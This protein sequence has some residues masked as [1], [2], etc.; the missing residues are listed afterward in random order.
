MHYF[1]G[2]MHS[3]AY[4]QPRR[5]H[6]TQHDAEAALARICEGWL[7]DAGAAHLARRGHRDGEFDWNVL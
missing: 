7:A 6:A 4:R 1:T 3:H 2:V 5:A